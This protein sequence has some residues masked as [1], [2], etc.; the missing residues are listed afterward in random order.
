MLKVVPEVAMTNGRIAILGTGKISIA[1]QFVYKSM[2]NEVQVFGR[3]S[4]DALKCHEAI[5]T[6][7]DYDPDV[8]YNTIALAGVEGCIEECE[9]SFLIQSYFPLQLAKFVAQMNICLI[10][11]SSS[12]VYSDEQYKKLAT[13]SVLPKP[14]NIYGLTKYGADCFVEQYAQKFYV[15]RFPRVF[16]PSVKKNQF[17]EK[18]IHTGLKTKKLNISQ[19][20]FDRPIYSIDVAKAMVNIVSNT[21]PYGIYHFASMNECSLYDLCEKA[22]EYLCLDIEVNRVD[23]SLFIDNDSKNTICNLCSE[24]I[25][26][27]RNWEES[28]KDYCDNWK[29]S[30]IDVL[31]LEDYICTK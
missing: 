27:L 21:M 14:H 17:L 5:A 24:K 20:I 16:G 10:Q 11:M 29:N 26:P 1:L 25:Q 3:D 7:K 12:C 2:K 18:M 9:K 13:E 6:L 22:V 28:L 4:I 30:L 8:V 15:F 31:V 23:S 19:D